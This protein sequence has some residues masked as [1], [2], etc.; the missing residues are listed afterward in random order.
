LQTDNE[1]YRLSLYRRFWWAEGAGWRLAVGVGFVML[2]SGALLGALMWA[3]PFFLEPPRR[4]D[5]VPVAGVVQTA[6][7]NSDEIVI[8]LE[9]HPL[10]FRYGEKSGA[11]DVVSGAVAPGVTVELLASAAQLSAADGDVSIYGVTVDGRTVRT[12]EDVERTWR[13]DN[14]TIRHVLG[15]IF[16]AI[17]AFVAALFFATA[18]HEQ[19]LDPT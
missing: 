11:L 8:A 3:L 9:G 4:A 16:L 19:R 6:V 14:D 7:L 1:A 13:R 10:A 17:G 2:G 15:P 18:I 5:L 12:F